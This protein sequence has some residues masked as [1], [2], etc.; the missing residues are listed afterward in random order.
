[1]AVKAGDT[2]QAGQVIGIMGSTGVSTGT[3]LHF[4]VHEEGANYYLDPEQ[5]TYISDD[6]V[7]KTFYV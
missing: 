5:F 4:D 3:H 2:I 7:P 1:M 6:V